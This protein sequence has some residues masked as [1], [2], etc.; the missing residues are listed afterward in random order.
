[1]FSLLSLFLP[2]LPRSKTPWTL[3]A[4]VVAILRCH[5]SLWVVLHLPSGCGEPHDLCWLQ[6]SRSQADLLHN[7]QSLCSRYS[8][9]FHQLR[10]LEELW[11]MHVPNLLSTI[12][13]T[14]HPTSQMLGLPLL[15]MSLPLP[16][17]SQESHLGVWSAN[18]LSGQVPMETG[19]CIYSWAAP[20]PRAG[21]PGKSYLCPLLGSPSLSHTPSPWCLCPLSAPVAA[22]PSCRNLP[23]SDLGPK[24]STC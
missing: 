24:E 15:L 21:L 13:R 7:S 1:M 23:F 11:V 18:P 19:S 10:H 12:D 9:T 4:R 20:T 2:L 8:F 6:S 17:L 3:F 22:P 14:F 16:Q 5:L